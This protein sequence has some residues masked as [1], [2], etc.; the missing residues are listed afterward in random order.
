MRKFA[1]YGRL[2]TKDK[3]DPTLSFPSQREACATKAAEL[4]GRIVCD[5]TDQE[6]GRRDDRAG[7]G[8]LIRE[9]KERDARR[10]DAVI[11]YSTSRLSPRAVPRA[12]LRAR[13]GAG[14]RRDLLRADRG[15]P[16]QPRGAADP[17]HVPGTRPVR[18]REARPRGAPRA[19]REHQAGLPQR[20]PRPLRLPTPARGPPRP[21]ARPCRGQEVAARRR[22]RAGAGDRRDV[23]PLP[24]RLR[25]QGDRRPPEPPRRS[26]LPAPRRLQPQHLGQ[27]VEDDDPLDAREPRLHRAPLLEPA[28]LPRHQAG[29]GTAG[30]PRPRGMDRGRA[31]PRGAGLRGGLRARPGR[32][33]GAQHR[34]VRQ[35]PPQGAEPLLPAARNRPLRHRPQPAADAGQ[36]AA[37]GTPTTPAATGS[38]TATRRP[39]PPATA[40]GSTSARS[41]CWL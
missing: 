2:S 11:V 38:P 20:R 32:D 24:R 41:R 3:Q 23:R 17:P 28:R 27:V 4:G 16:D 26:P 33:E 36:D 29:R 6:T 1:W 12:G 22:P 21:G 8:E 39:R 35:P 10:F 14:G 40:N 37:R 9:A 13:A 5:F 30:P 7:W 25:L 18:G 31:P 15:R 19:D 34:P